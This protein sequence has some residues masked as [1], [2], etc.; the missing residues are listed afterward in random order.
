MIT[1]RGRKRSLNAMMHVV[2]S[3]KSR[4][5][6]EEGSEQLHVIQIQTSLN[7]TFHMLLI[8]WEHC[9]G[10]ILIKIIFYLS[11]LICLI[12]YIDAPSI[13]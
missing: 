1:C 5:K 10:T 9:G 7:T 11:Y 6:T 13:W 12:I 4:Y 8:N 2:Q 3:M